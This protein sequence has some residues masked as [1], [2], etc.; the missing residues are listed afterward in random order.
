MRVRASGL[1]AHLQ[2][3][4]DVRHNLVLKSTVLALRVFSAQHAKM[5]NAQSHC[6]MTPQTL[7]LDLDPALTLTL[8]LTHT[9]LATTLSGF[10]SA[11][12]E[13][14]RGRGSLGDA[15][16]R[17][18]AWQRHCSLRTPPGDSMRQGCCTA[19]LPPDA[20]TAAL[21][22]PSPGLYAGP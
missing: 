22:C 3:L 4:H 8:N 14:H 5:L 18:R 21:H 17:Q 1:R 7:T 16:G 10:A 20:T 6:Y 13:R 19:I 9:T 11:I 15:V 12:A 2:A